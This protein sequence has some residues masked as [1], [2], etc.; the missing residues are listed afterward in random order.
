MQCWGPKLCL[1]SVYAVLGFVLRGKF[2]K[3]FF[4]VIVVET[5]LIGLLIPDLPKPTQIALPMICSCF[6]RMAC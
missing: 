4:P 5:V 3:A 1:S 6:S 2:W